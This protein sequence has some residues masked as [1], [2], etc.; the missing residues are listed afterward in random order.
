MLPTPTK[1]LPVTGHPPVRAAGDHLVPRNTE[2][3]PAATA[4]DGCTVVM[5]RKGPARSRRVH[6]RGRNRPYSSPPGPPPQVVSN[7]TRQWVGGGG[8]LKKMGKDRN[9]VVI[10]ICI[11]FGIGLLYVPF[12]SQ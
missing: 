6:I 8:L 4:A 12:S 2:D 9:F 11:S 7:P 3:F 10:I 5:R 1:D